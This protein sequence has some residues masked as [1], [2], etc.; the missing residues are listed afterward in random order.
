M[1][2]G[3]GSGAPDVTVLVP[4]YNVERYL[5]ESLRSLEDQTLES[6]EVLVINDGSTDSSRDIVAEHMAADPRIRVIDKPNSGYGDSIN[7]GIEEARGRYVGILEPDD[8][9]VPGALEMLVGL[10][11]EH[12]ADIVKANYWFYWSGPEKRDMLIEVVTPKMADHAFRPVDEPD[13]FFSNPSIWSAVY[14]RGFLMETGVR[15][16]A[17]PGASFQDLGFAFKSWASAERVW[18]T[19]EPVIHYRQDNES[20][21]VNNPGKVFCVCDEFDSIDEFVESSPDAE[22]LRAYAFRLRYDSY[23]WNFERLSAEMRGVF[24]DRMVSDLRA[25]VEAG[26]MDESLFARYQAKNLR[27]ILEDPAGFVRDFPLSPTRSSKM[28]YYLL[29]QGPRAVAEIMRG[30]GGTP[31]GQ[32]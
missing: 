30:R 22:R 17:T 5:D 32:G 18:C 1:L 31:A 20:S 24:I 16:L 11:D 21:S 14:R 4:V 10:A 28:M 27:R 3:C 15:C 29:T 23:M 12:S 19:S 6:I 26:A 8:I 25:G 7:R 13:V 2:P 9:M